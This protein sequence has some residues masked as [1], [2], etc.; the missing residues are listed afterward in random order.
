MRATRILET[1]IYGADLAAMQGFYEGT[2]GL[3]VHSRLEGKFVFFR[4]A[5]Q[6]LLVFN[7]ELSSVQRIEDGPPPH[8]PRGQGH[9]C[10]RCASD[11]LARWQAH[12]AGHG[13]LVE[14]TIDWPAGG[15]SIYFRDPAGNSVEFSDGT[16]W[17]FAPLRSLANRRVVVATHNRGKLAEFAT[18]LAPFG[19]ETVSAGDLGLAEPAETETSFAG[20]ARIKAHA[21]MAASGLVALSDDS[22]LCIAALDGA[23]GVYTADW[24]GPERD[25]SRAMRL[26]E[27]KLMAVGASVPVIFASRPRRCRCPSAFS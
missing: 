24:A 14:R 2:L 13:V 20:N 9:I 1:V 3:S 17:G 25:W 23:P 7:A 5:E 11:E 12:L 4:L 27:D 6:M 8:G 15:R 21:A 22:G 18:L 16:L 26:V 10:F 19:V